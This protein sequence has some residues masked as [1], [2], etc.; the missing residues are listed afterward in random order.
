MSCG[1][2]WLFAKENFYIA[3]LK[4]I[5]ELGITVPPCG[6]VCW[7]KCPTLEFVCLL[8]TEYIK[9]HFGIFMLISETPEVQYYPPLKRWERNLILNSFFFFVNAV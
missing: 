9:A 2:F 1:T 5:V 4:R 3:G 6:K 7:E 8:A